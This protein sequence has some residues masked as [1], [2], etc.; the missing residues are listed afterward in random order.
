MRKLGRV[1]PIAINS[2][3]MVANLGHCFLAFPFEDNEICLL[4][5]H[6]AVN[7]ITCDFSALL[8][9]NPTAFDVVA[10]QTLL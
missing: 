2:D 8:G 4:P 1:R 7:A 9:K 6:M 5:G 3:L 10:A